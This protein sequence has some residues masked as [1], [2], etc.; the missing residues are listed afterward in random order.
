MLA[1]VLKEQK[2]MLVQEDIPKP[3]PKD[4][5]LLIKVKVCG[6]C[7]TDLHVKDGD[8]PHP[9]LP[10]VLGHE[11]VGVVE[12]IGKNVKGFKEGDRV[13]V[14]WL[15]KSCGQCEFCQKGDENLCD[16]AQYT[17]YHVDGGFAEYTVCNADFAILLPT[18]PSDEQI[19]PLLCAG[20][21]GYRAYRKAAPQ[22][23]LGL[24]GFG[25]A[26]HLLTQLA[27][28]EG[29]K[30]YAF[31]RAGDKKGQ[32]FA[33]Q[34]G[35]IWAGD[36]TASSPIPLDAAIIFAPIGA[37]V[38]VVLKAL[39]KGGRCICGGIHMS[40]IPSFPYHD[41]WG[42]RSI[43]SV[44]NLTRSDAKDFFELI[45]KFPIR[46]IVK[47]YPLEQANQALEDLKQGKF[48]GAAVLRVCR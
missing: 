28:H 39:K 2:K 31:T 24:Y 15:G 13:G 33:R 1:M 12:E 9:K 20:L 36:S 29:K 44:A 43:Q 35:A 10:L 48:Q 16:N 34:L 21:I 38:P 42:E 26:A 46:P 30:V 8:L 41:L 45:S 47:V 19:A 4:D 40:D 14:A 23:T 18:A 37:L 11:I 6:V 32:E 5:E 27:I 25:A 17:G 3:K 22:K 7:R